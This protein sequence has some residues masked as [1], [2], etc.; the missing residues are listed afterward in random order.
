MAASL[1]LKAEQ[2]GAHSG[3]VTS[4]SVAFSPDGKTIVSGS[5]DKTIKVWDAGVLALTPSNP[6]YPL[7]LCGAGKKHVLLWPPHTDTLQ[8][9]EEREGDGSALDASGSGAVAER[10]GATLRLKEGGGVFYA[11]GPL[12]SV[13]VHWPR[14]VAGAASGELYHLEV[15]REELVACANAV[16]K[17]KKGLAKAAA[18]EKKSSS[19]NIL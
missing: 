5:S 2:Q 7:D 9:V 10:D 13:A 19:C 11:P 4:C 3:W 14:L 1:E 6:Y 16:A 8:L 17:S 12:Q 18:S 15:E